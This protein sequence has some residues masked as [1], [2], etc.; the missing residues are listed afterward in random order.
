MPFLNP[1]KQKHALEQV[2]SD[3]PDSD[4]RV[5]IFPPP[6]IQRWFWGKF[7]IPAIEG[8]LGN[9]DLFHATSFIMPPLKRAKGVLTIYDLTFKL[10]PNATRKGCRLLPE[11]YSDL[12]I[13]P[14]VSSPFQSTPSAMLWS[15]WAYLKKES[16]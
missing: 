7:D 3:Y 1:Q 14:I 11:T 13:V 10:F 6:K 2:A 9:I 5:H 15:I 4:I 8:Y 12:L 16:A